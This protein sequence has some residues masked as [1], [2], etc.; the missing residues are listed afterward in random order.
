M[1]IDIDIHISLYIYMYIYIY[2][3]IYICMYIVYSTKRNNKLVV[4]SH[5]S[6]SSNLLVAL[7]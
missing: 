5:K 7:R 6:G 1:D 2:I 4:N 3:Y